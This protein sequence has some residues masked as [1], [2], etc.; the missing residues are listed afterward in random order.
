MKTDR[1]A[2]V[3]NVNREDVVTAIKVL[4]EFN[5]LRDRI[6]KS[7]KIDSEGVEYFTGMKQ[8]TEVLIA[9]L[10]QGL[11]II[12]KH[13]LEVVIGEGSDKVN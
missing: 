5:K 1:V 3:L 10:E 8:V 2:I 7:P 9:D 4:E 6:M 11:S 13:G 12:D